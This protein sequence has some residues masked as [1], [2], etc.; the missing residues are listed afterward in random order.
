MSLLRVLFVIVIL[1]S[2]YVSAAHGMTVEVAA[3]TCCDHPEEDNGCDEGTCGGCLVQAAVVTGMAIS[4]VFAKPALEPLPAP[5]LAREA[6]LFHLR[7]PDIL[8]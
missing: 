3:I 2:G 8:A 1:F 6:L 5:V 7:P 4:S